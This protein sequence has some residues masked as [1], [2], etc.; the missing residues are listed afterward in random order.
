M[1]TPI[2]ILWTLLSILVAGTCSF[3]FLQ[4]FWLIQPVT[5]YSFGVFTYCIQSP[6][7]AMPTGGGGGGTAAAGQGNGATEQQCGVYGKQFNLSNLPSNAWQASCVL[8]GAGCI[9][10]CTAAL[11]A[12]VSMC[13]PTDYDKRMAAITGYMQCVAGNLCPVGSYISV[14]SIPSWD[15]Q[16]IKYSPTIKLACIYL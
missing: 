4:P 3:A 7:D 11:L 6:G 2:G 13:V 15:V 8:Y 9:F 10:L 12:M 14:S 5:L 16:R 1:S